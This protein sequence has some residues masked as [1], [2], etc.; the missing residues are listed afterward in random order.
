MNQ[1]QIEESIKT[2]NL[3]LFKLLL[4]PRKT[5]ITILE[6]NNLEDFYQFIYEVIYTESYIR[7][8]PE[9]NFEF[10]KDFKLYDNEPIKLDIEFKEKLCKDISW[11]ANEGISKIYNESFAFF[12]CPYKFLL[13]CQKY[14]SV[15]IF[16]EYIVCIAKMVNLIFDSIEFTEEYCNMLNYE[17]IKTT[18]KSI[19][20]NKSDKLLSIINFY[21]KTV[22]GSRYYYGDCYL[23]LWEKDLLV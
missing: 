3:D 14:S 11:R 12:L 22:Y 5:L 21:K 16:N 19:D 18:I 20:E 6:N 1:L 13:L 23:S 8:A 7:I 2:N 15:N 10:D 9:P 17:I 4:D